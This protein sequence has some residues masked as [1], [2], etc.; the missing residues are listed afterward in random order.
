MV[1]SP[2]EEGDKIREATDLPNLC[3]FQDFVRENFSPKSY[4]A[5]YLYHSYFFLAL[6][7]RVFFFF[8]TLSQCHF[9]FHN[10]QVVLILNTNIYICRV[11]S[12]S[13]SKNRDTLD[14]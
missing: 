1:N 5:L 9:H 7:A 10:L 14:Y 6:V 13:I 11:C 3:E 8:R 4:E 12:N 2:N